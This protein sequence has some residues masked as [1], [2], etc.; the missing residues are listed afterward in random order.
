MVSYDEYLNEGE[1]HLTYFQELADLQPDYSVLEAGCGTGR[2]ALPLT[3][4][5][6]NKGEYQGF[7]DAKGDINWCKKNISEKHPNFHFQYTESKNRTSGTSTN[8]DAA[9]FV[10]PYDDAKFD[11]VFLSSVFTYLKPADVE[12]YINEIG[13]VMKPGATSLMTLFIV[14]CVSEDLMIKKPTQMH[15]P[16]NKGFYRLRS[17][18]ADKKQIAYD[19]EWILEKLQN[20][21]LKMESIQYGSWCGRQHFFDF[22]DL[23]ICSKE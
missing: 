2:M 19:E 16:F 12:N 21:G 20:A 17:L 6:N 15:F 8:A 9:H 22:P 10:F 4:F 1:K 11:F 14:N 18:Q 23:I 5:L 7:D 13:R 3:R